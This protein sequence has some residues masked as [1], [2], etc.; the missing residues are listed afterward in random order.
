VSGARR[1][2]HGDWD[3]VLETNY[4]YEA[5]FA[6]LRLRAA[7]VE[8]RVIDQSYRQE[9]VPFVRSLSTVRVLVPVE[10]A[11]EARSLLE[12]EKGLPEGAEEGEET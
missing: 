11:L 5:E 6:A 4:A 10:R 7:G 2:S 3:V 9:P 8:T 12:H 1:G